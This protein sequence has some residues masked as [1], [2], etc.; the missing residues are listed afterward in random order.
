MA[1]LIPRLLHRDWLLHLLLLTLLLLLRRACRKRVGLQV[2]LLLLLLSW[3]QKEEELWLLLWLQQHRVR[4]AGCG[5]PR[6]WPQQANNT[7]ARLPALSGGGAISC[8]MKAASG[9][10]GEVVCL[11]GAARVGVV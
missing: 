4:L 2:P 7:A 9:C 11:V 10:K 8:C 1:Q 5:M 6:G 3:G